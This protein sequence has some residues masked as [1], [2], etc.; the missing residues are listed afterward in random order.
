MS[1]FGSINPWVSMWASPRK[2]I[3]ALVDFKPNYGVFYLASLFAFQDLLYS[4]NWWSLGTKFS[5]LSIFLGSLVFCPFLGLVWIYFAGWIFHFTGR[6]L[7]GKAPASHLRAALAWSKVPVSLNLLAWLGVLFF[8][9]HSAFILDGS[10][11]S[12]FFSSIFLIFISLISGIWSFVLLVQSIREIQHFSLG[13]SII[14][15]VMGW[16]IYFLFFVIFSGL[17]RYFYLLL[18]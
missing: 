16:V 12:G 1:H 10:R 6:W 15:V 3:R 13:H 9:A 2:T 4:A 7:H 11:D 14:N 5:P 17:V 8:G 18:T